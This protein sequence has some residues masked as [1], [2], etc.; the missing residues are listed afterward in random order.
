MCM[1]RRYFHSSIH[2][3]ETLFENQKDDG[4]VL[5]ALQDELT[6]RKTERAVKLRQRIAIRLTQ[7]GICTSPSTLQKDVLQFETLPNIKSDVIVEACADRLTVPHKW[8]DPTDLTSS[9]L[10]ARI[11]NHSRR[12]VPPVTKAP[13]SIL[14][15][16]T[17]LEVLS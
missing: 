8:A 4:S 9:T 17:A 10:Q 11:K 12:P 1:N 13:E 15:A 3:L 16:W 5:K 2:D 14:S 6:H 7:L